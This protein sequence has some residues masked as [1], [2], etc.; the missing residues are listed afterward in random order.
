MGVTILG[1]V[2]GALKST[3]E[4]NMEQRTI[5]TMDNSNLAWNRCGVPVVVVL[6]DFDI[7]PTRMAMSCLN[8]TSVG[9]LQLVT[10]LLV[11]S[12]VSRRTEAANLSDAENWFPALG[13]ADF[14]S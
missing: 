9:A 12:C 7:I 5:N 2:H 10:V 3:C 4:I 14:V 1:I 8:I 13:L 6:G 11:F